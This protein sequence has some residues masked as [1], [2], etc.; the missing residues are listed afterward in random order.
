MTVRINF[1]VILFV[2]IL[3]TMLGNGVANSTPSVRI[4]PQ[5]LKQGDVALVEVQGPDRDN[6]VRVAFSN[7]NFPL[8]YDAASKTFYG[9]LGVDLGLR[10]GAYPLTIIV[11]GNSMQLPVYVQDVDFGTRDLTLPPSMTQFD[12]KT[13]ARIRREQKLIKSV[14]K[15][16]SRRVLWDGPFI[17]PVPGEITG[18]FGRRTV[19]NGEPRSPHSGVDLRAKKNDNIFCSNSGRVVL[20]QDL[21]FSGKTVV[22]DHGLG[23]FT[24]YFHLSEILVKV[25]EPVKTN[26]IIGKAGSTGRSTG[27]HLHWGV[28]INNERVDPMK[29]IEISSHFSKRATM[30]ER[31]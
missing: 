10:A 30:A 20:A 6:K 4:T 3:V 15:K 2:F 23:L 27:P 5:S 22:I 18:P 12:D 26:Q 25:G 21:F 9:L 16:S 11:D 24:M 14:W 17:R 31:P 13:L 19:I 28:R 1:C 8:T 29:L 7:E